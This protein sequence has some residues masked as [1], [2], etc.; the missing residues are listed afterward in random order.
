[1]SLPNLIANIRNATKANKSKTKVK[2]TKINLNFLE[3]LRQHKF[4]S[5]YL[6]TQDNK[7]IVFLKYAFNKPCILNL[8]NLRKTTC[9]L[10]YSF[11]D[12]CKFNKNLGFV[13]LTTSKGIITHKTAL[14]RGVG[15]MALAY[16]I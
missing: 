4:I 13:I 1:M 15:G 5:G 8:V 2:I 6:R 9:P 11:S 16:I 3:I 14:K 7:V 10:C 12:L